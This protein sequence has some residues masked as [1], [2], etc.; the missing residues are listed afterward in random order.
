M[1]CFF[2]VKKPTVSVNNTKCISHCKFIS[3]LE[4]PTLVSRILQTE[5]SIF[6]CS[7]LAYL[8]FFSWCCWTWIT[9]LGTK[10][11]HS[12][13]LSYPHSCIAF[14]LTFIFIFLATD[15]K[16]QLQSLLDLNHQAQALKAVHQHTEQFASFCVPSIWCYVLVFSLSSEHFFKIV[17]HNPANSKDFKL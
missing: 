3:R 5:L 12:C 11:H 7:L 14:L 1:V 6:L 4:P 17:F 8:S 15:S 9:N 2:L 13:T 16:M 10:R